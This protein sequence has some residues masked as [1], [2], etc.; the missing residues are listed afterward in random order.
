MCKL[1]HLIWIASGRRGRREEGKGEGGRVGG[2]CRKGG[3]GGKEKEK[4]EG[5]KEKLEGTSRKKTNH[6][7]SDAIS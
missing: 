4:E 1:L 5:K 7:D 2:E 3:D 6:C